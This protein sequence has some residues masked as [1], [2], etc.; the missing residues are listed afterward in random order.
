M[1]ASGA[2]L[3]FE[4]DECERKFS[5]KQG[6]T[7]H[8]TMTHTKP[9]ENNKKVDALKRTRSI[10][11]KNSSNSCVK[12]SYSSRSKWAL[13][14]HINHKHKEPT[15]PNE[16]K[17]RIS[18]E[19]KEV[20][21]TILSEVVENITNAFEKDDKQKI[22]IEPTMDF[23]TNTAATLAEML[24][25]VADHVEDVQGDDSDMEELEDRLD[26]L[27]G[28]RPRNRRVIADQEGETTLVTLPLKDVEE[29]RLRL[30]NLED[31]NDKLSNALGDVKE[32][33]LKYR[34]LEDTNKELLYKLKE[35]EDKKKD[36]KNKQREEFIVINMEVDNEDEGIEQLLKNK[37]D[38]YTRMNPQNEAQQRKKVSDSYNCTSC[39][40]KFGRKEEM[41]SHQKTHEV[42]CTLCEKIFKTGDKLKEH[43]KD[44]EEMIC[45]MQCEG[46]SC[47]IDE[48][49]NTQID[50]K[51][52]CK[53]CDE[54][55]SS[56]NALSTHK[57]DVHRTYKPCRDI[58]NCVYQAG[59]YF[60]H[61]P[62]PHYLRKI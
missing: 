30:R 31:K 56:N 34:L 39:E 52:A 40:R 19:V 38:G 47:S 45:H 29:L 37:R 1:K 20:V 21:E 18:T 26:I 27:R 53:F 17:P 32:L 15:S 62:T 3:D 57:R 36:K 60:S 58:A 46:G 5:T 50:N 8:K 61:V 25:S 33:N 9:R 49:Q 51:H 59:C 4:C 12:C 41:A 11:E 7:R 42:R 43:L 16:K 10:A 24:D 22:T 55:F 23:L 2:V 6:R 44:H 28:D 14:A 13:K 54:K 48:T 35:I